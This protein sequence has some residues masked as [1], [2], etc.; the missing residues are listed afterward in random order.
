MAKNDPP[1]AVT[2]T[3][4]RYVADISELVGKLRVNRLSHDPMLR[5]SNRI[6]TIQSTLAIEQN[7][8]SVEQVTAVLDGKRVLAPPRE[9]AEVRNAARAYEMMDEL[10]PYSVDSLLEAHGVMMRGLIDE[11]GTFR[12]GAVGVV[13]A[14]GNILHFGTLPRYVPESVE[15]LLDWVRESELPML[16]KS[17]VFHYELEL[18]HPFSDGNG[19]LGRLWHTLLLTQWSPL[20]A[21]LPIESVIRERQQ[22]YY[23]A[24]NAANLA[25]ESTIF[26]EF[27]LSAIRAALP[28]DT[29]TS[30]KAEARRRFV[31]EYLSS[32]P[33][34]SNTDVCRGLGV[35]S[36]T[37]NRILSELWHSGALERKRIG[38]TWG[39]VKKNE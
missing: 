2:Q 9:I 22:E 10:D 14:E 15:Q 17:C 1:F 7:T 19:R 36:A 3:M 4:L 31:L 25:G 34:I 28:E 39:Y 16:I 12:E 18:I 38:K 21:W 33:H 11:A 24:I 27:M 13:D 30:G 37:A 8:L 20:F 23:D 29:G 32:H 6:R 5:R 35:S 26:I